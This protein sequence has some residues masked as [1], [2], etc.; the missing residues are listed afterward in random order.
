M[1][2]NRWEIEQSA[3]RYQDD[4]IL[5]PAT[6]FLRDFMEQVDNNSDGW[7]Y[8]QAPAKAAEKLMTLI[9]RGLPGNEA[10]FKATL[11]PIKSFY[12]RKG[13]TAGMT[14]P[15]VLFHGKKL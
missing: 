3:D 9:Q 6:Q 5:G 1:W 7:A 13:Y 2:M 11:S 14:W 12:T 10:D 15:V 8:W 4:A